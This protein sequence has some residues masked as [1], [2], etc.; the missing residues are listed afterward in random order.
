MLNR[1]EVIVNLF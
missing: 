1:I